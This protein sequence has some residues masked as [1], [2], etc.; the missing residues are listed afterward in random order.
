MQCVRRSILSGGA[1]QQIVA[2]NWNS[3]YSQ[4][5]V[6]V[7]NKI[8]ACNRNNFE[9]EYSQWCRP[10]ITASTHAELNIWLNLQQELSIIPMECVW[11]WRSICSSRI[12]GY[13]WLAH[14]TGNTWP[15][16]KFGK[17]YCHWICLQYNPH[18]SSYSSGPKSCTCPISSKCQEICVFFQWYDSTTQLKTWLNLRQECHVLMSLSILPSVCMED[19]SQWHT[20]LEKK[21]ALWAFSKIGRNCHW[22]YL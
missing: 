15:N 18:G 17:S 1:K 22:A 7:P 14:R 5:M 4:C 11:P 20:E 6:V 19:H 16:L 8:M 13:W 9:E 12:T 2:C 21:K 10:R 3:L